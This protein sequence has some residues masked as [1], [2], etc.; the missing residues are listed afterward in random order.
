MITAAKVLAMEP[1]Q[2]WVDL[3]QRLPICE[4]CTR[5]IATHM[6]QRFPQDPPGYYCH[7]CTN[8]YVPSHPVDVQRKDFRPLPWATHVKAAEAK[9]IGVP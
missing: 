6:V 2:R 1:E 5:R 9:G 4:E 7:V 3:V 8:A